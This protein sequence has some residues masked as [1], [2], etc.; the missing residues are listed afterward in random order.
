MMNENS[1]PHQEHNL[2]KK[3]VYAMQWVKYL[4]FIIIISSKNS[5]RP[6][7]SSSRRPHE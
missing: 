4:F 1:N 7:A 5:N 3:K 6:T 2:P